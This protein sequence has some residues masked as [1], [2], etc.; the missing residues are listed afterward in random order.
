MDKHKSQLEAV[1]KKLNGKR[2]A[3]TDT[4]THTLIHNFHNKNLLKNCLT[5]WEKWLQKITE[6]KLIP[7]LTRTTH[8]TPES[9]HLKETLE[10]E[11][12]REYLIG[13]RQCI[14][15]VY[16]CLVVLCLCVSRLLLGSKDKGYHHQVCFQV[17]ER[18]RVEK[19]SG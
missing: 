16:A 4:H 7:S 18:S 6:L 1:K 2:M 5:L 11:E 8:F 10:E 3:N 14:S 19:Q 9:G 15:V 13:V 12:R 17:E